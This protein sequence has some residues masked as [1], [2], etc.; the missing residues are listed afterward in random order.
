MLLTLSIR[1]I[2]LIDQ[3]E[4]NWTAGLSTLTG[5]TGAGKSILL[6]AL[7][8]A[9]G[10]RGDASMVRHGVDQG[11][12]T[13][14]F[15]LHERDDIL[16]LLEENG[17]P[18]GDELILR[19]IQHK[20]GRSRAFINDTPT[21]VGLLA[22]I[23]DAMVE[24]HG[25]SENQALIAPATQLSLLDAFGG[26]SPQVQKVTQ[27]FQ[28]WRTDADAWQAYQERQQAGNEEIAFLQASVSEL[29]ALDPKP[30]EVD[31]LAAARALQKNIGRLTVDMTEALN[32]LA[33]DGGAEL[34]L[35]R[36]VGLI[37]KLA[38][39]A[40]GALDESLAG[41]QRAEVE[42]NEARRLLDDVAAH[43]DADPLALER[44]EDRL[45]ALKD[46]ARKHRV[47]PDGL[48]S[49]LADMRE[50]LNALDDDPAIGKKLH[51]ACEK[52]QAQLDDAAAQLTAARHTAALGLAEA[53][54]GEL[55][56]LK[57]DGATFRVAV[58]A[59]EQIGPQGRD[60]IR[61]V[62]QT[63][64]GTPEGPISKIAS[65][66]ELAR[67]MLAL[68]VVL[69]PSDHSHTLI[70]DEVDAGVGGA[71]AE[72]VGARLSR[73]AQKHQVLVVTHSPQVAAR[74]DQQWR[75][76]KDQQ[77]SGATRTQVD[78]LDLGARREEIARMLSGAEITD[79][80]RAAAD[81]LLAVS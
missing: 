7:G 2:V 74:G 49:L 47:E 4:L 60:K 63:N 37:E 15:S 43:M 36:A 69:A 3:L 17:I 75:V 1:D 8:L 73:V 77:N 53:V 14:I 40:E 45:F 6:D 11:S 39:M 46:L 61:F 10:A 26:L 59:A 9:I 30:G 38:P 65:G 70:F 55:L 24:I 48:P 76:F 79:E 62:A 16:S 13:A 19:R 57:L 52:S 66:G 25:Q 64:P 18:A 50:R 78:V 23:G 20:D 44:L 72:A 5:E 21:S 22:Q 31:E 33:G 71:V 29:T 58:E 28:Q 68:K 42:L 80:A 41:L 35:S 51:A 56:S 54:N 12:V 34:G 67:F 81:R 27:A 32:S